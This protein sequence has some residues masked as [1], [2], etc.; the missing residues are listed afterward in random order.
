MVPD[1]DYDMVN[2][3]Q[4]EELGAVLTSLGLLVHEGLLVARSASTEDQLRLEL[5]FRINVPVLLHL[6]V[7]ERVVV[8]QVSTTALGLQA[9]PEHVLVHGGR[10]L[11]PSRELLGVGR[12]G[13]CCLAD[14]GNRLVEENLV[15][16]LISLAL[17]M[18]SK[19]TH[20]SKSVSE[21]I[22][23][24]LASGFLRLVSEMRLQ[25][26]PDKVPELV[27]LGV[28][29]DHKTGGLAVEGAGDVLHGCVDELLDARVADGQVLVEH[30]DAAT[31]DDGVGEGDLVD[32]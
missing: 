3:L 19:D 12:V 1:K 7:D 17:M 24:S 32:V 16:I 23:S 8:L 11:G 31:G 29:Q 20:S 14:F 18:I 9:S 4:A 28:Q 22:N 21:S 5:P 27:V 30:V 15:G 25:R 10:V 13:R 6:G 26:L 2:L